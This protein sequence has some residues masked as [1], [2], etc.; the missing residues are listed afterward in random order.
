MKNTNEMRRLLCEIYA[1]ADNDE[2]K[3]LPGELLACFPRI[4]DL[5]DKALTLLPCE[6]CDGTKQVSTSR[7]IGFGN[8]IM[9]TCTDCQPK[10]LEKQ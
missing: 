8:A 9:D 1:I 3:P 7:S 5:A 10:L 6:T 4:M 2:P